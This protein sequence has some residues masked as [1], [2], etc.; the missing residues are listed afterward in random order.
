MKPG[1]ESEPVSSILILKM[2]EKPKTLQYLKY[3][4]Y[5]KERG[6]YEFSFIF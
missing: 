4:F 3:L 2:N 6:V 1:P 5:R